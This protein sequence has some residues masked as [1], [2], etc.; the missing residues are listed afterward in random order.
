MSSST[1]GETGFNDLA[2]GG[3]PL[4]RLLYLRLFRKGDIPPR[5]DGTLEDTAESGLRA[6][7]EKADLILCL[8]FFAAPPLRES[9]G[10]ES[11]ASGERGTYF[12]LGASL[13]TFDSRVDFLRGLGGR[14]CMPLP[15]VPS[16]SSET[17]TT[18]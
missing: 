16:L 4:F 6:G 1:T 2:F 5:T 9:L 7:D 11:T 14:F 17:L 18:L 15:E 8:V 10:G 12:V 3:E 13:D